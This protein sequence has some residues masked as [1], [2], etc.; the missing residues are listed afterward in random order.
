MHPN[1]AEAMSGKTCEHKMG[2]Y[3]EGSIFNAPR[4]YEVCG[5]RAH[6]VARYPKQAEMFL[7]SRHAKTRHFTERLDAG[8]SPHNA[9]ENPTP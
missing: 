7:C 5:K 9:N 3:R 4:E 6:W 2:H 8:I 1:Q